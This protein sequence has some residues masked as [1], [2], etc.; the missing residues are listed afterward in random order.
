MKRFTIAL[1]LIATAVFG[2]GI[3]QAQDTMNRIDIVRP[4]APELATEGEYNIGVQTL[5]LV[6]PEGY[7]I[8]NAV[9]GE[10]IEQYD[11]PLTMEVWYPADVADDAEPTPYNVLTRDTEIEATLIGRAVRDAAPLMDD[12]PYPLVIISH[13]YPGNRFLMSHLG[14]NLATKGYV[15][16]SVDHTDST[17]SDQAAF[18]STLVNRPLDQ[19]FVLEQMSQ[20]GATDS[21]SFLAGLVDADNTAIIGYSMGG[22]GALNAIGGGFTEESIGLSFAPPNEGLRVRQAGNEMYED[23]FD[24]RIQAVVAIGPWGMNTGFW[25]DETLAGIEDVPILF[26]AGGVDDVSGYEEGVRAIWEGVANTDRHLLTFE[27]ANHNA[28]APM[29]APRE[30]LEAG[31]GYDHYSDAVWDNTR[32]N[33]IAQH[34]ATAFLGVHLQGDE[35]LQDYLTVEVESAAEGVYAVDDDGNFTEEHTYWPGFPNRTAVGLTLEFAGA[36]E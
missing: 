6:N 21:D 35:E 12:G 2:A 5:E 20:L 25:N 13:G 7:D 8:V 4:D 26:M 30:V 34:F 10:P 11:R 22:Y 15:T 31:S 36:G 1:L 28:A 27:N 32:M 18:G 16:V 23:T 33:N 17:Y 29:R 9:E 3:V 19:L 24:E 14:E